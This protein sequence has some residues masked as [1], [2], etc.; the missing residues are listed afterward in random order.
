MKKSIPK[1]DKHL[2]LMGAHVLEV[3]FIDKESESC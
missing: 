1:V 3:A 2:S